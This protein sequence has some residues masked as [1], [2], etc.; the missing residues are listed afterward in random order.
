[1]TEAAITPADYYQANIAREQSYMRVYMARKVKAGEEVEVGYNNMVTAA[2]DSYLISGGN[3]HAD[4]RDRLMTA[5]EFAEKTKPAGSLAL[6]E[7]RQDLTMKIVKA[8]AK[9]ELVKLYGLKKPTQARA[10]GFVVNNGNTDIFMTNH[11]LA[12]KF[13][14][15]GE[16]RVTQE[17][18]LVTINYETPIRG[19]LIQ[20]RTAFQL[21]TYVH[22]ESSGLLYRDPVSEQGYVVRF[23]N[24]V[25][26]D[27]R[28]APGQK[29]P[30]PKTAA[31]KAG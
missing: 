29:T 9:G 10:D 24:S 30:A 23:E 6:P 11:E 15:A 26:T 25:N 22:H 20:E 19:I 14:Y 28:L 13:N 17:L 4:Q 31:P 16:K 7:P 18:Q 27:L 1:M 21:K 12:S 5:T 8:A 3:G 2:V